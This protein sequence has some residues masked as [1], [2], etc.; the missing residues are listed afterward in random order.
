MKIIQCSDS[1]IIIKDNQVF[2]FSLLGLAEELGIEAISS[3]EILASTEKPGQFYMSIWK[4]TFV[5]NEI[6]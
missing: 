2:T 1:Y 5:D 6:K 3:Y 4:D